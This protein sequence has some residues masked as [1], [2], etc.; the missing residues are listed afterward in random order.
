MTNGPLL[1]LYLHI[2]NFIGVLY[3]EKVDYVITAPDC[4]IFTNLKQITINVG[5]LKPDFL[6]GAFIGLEICDFQIDWID[7][8]QESKLIT[9][10]GDNNTL[11]RNIE[12]SISKRT[13]GWCIYR[14]DVNDQCEK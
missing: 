11:K 3:F 5:G 12:V 10:G 9:T 7:E 8:M 1:I 6:K 13:E 2:I 4:I 14:L